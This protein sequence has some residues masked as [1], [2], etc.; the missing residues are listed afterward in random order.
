MLSN[1]LMLL[2]GEAPVYG[3]TPFTILN[4]DSF[5]GVTRDETQF[6]NFLGLRQFADVLTAAGILSAIII[7]LCSICVLYV[8]N[9][10]KTVAQTKEKIILGLS[11]IAYIAAFP[12]IA[13]VIYTII[14]D[15]FF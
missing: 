6:M 3:T 11:A 4:K 12:F 9:Y 2:D 10:A 1:F 13:D 8:A 15:A 7:I 5:T 14:K